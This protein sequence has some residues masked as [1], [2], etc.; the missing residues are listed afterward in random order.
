MRQ[1]ES[2]SIQ[3]RHV[4]LTCSIQKGEIRPGAGKGRATRGWGGRA[5]PET[6]VGP[7]AYR[8]SARKESNR[9]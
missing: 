4:K 8:N 5:D 2:V 3:K 6:E 9:T 7:R 1:I